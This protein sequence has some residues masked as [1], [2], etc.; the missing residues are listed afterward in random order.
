MR[1][2][3]HVK[4]FMAPTLIACALS[5]AALS[6][7]TGGPAPSPCT[8]DPP[9]KDRWVSEK[10]GLRMREAPDQNGKVIAVV[11]HAAKVEFISE[12]GETMNISGATGKW[13]EVKWNEKKGWVFGGFLGSADPAASDRELIAAA[14]R[15]NEEFSRK[16]WGDYPDRLKA[17][18]KYGARIREKSGN[19]A[20][21]E[22]GFF[23]ELERIE[24]TCSLWAR[25]TGRWHLVA[26]IESSRFGQNIK[27]V[28]LNNDDLIDAVVIYSSGDWNGFGFYV[29]KSAE[30]IE[31]AD[32]IPSIMVP[33]PGNIS[34]GRCGKT[35]ISGPV[36]ME[37]SDKG[38]V[39]TF[40]FDC[41]TNR[42]KK[43]NK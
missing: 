17:L 13:T 26:G 12:K 22:T 6:C 15:Y 9:S 21:V 2:H 42:L 23:E 33:M 30:T 31:K 10:Q 28:H 34:F 4:Q 25:T 16:S 20:V 1:K 35:R 7:S 40:I 29:A 41:A 24:K 5:V 27:L 19:V 43:I 37:D 14:G 3:A 39:T 18:I 36:S 38:R 8:V 11:P 32:S